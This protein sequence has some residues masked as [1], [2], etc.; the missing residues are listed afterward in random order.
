MGFY[1][2]AAKTLLAPEIGKQLAQ[3]ASIDPPTQP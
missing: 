1:L 2:A 3:D